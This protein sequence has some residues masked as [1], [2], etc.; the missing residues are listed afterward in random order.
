ME[1]TG[2]AFNEETGT[3]D[4]PTYHIEGDWYV[5]E[6][7]E[8]LYSDGGMMVGTPYIT[9]LESH[10]LREAQASE[11]KMS[12]I[13]SDRVRVSVP[14]MDR[15]FIVDTLEQCIRDEAGN[16]K[17][18]RM[19]ES[20]Y[21]TDTAYIALDNELLVVRSGDFPMIL[22]DRDDD[23][24]MFDMEDSDHGPELFAIMT[25]NHACFNPAEVGDVGVIGT[26]PFGKLEPYS[27]LAFEIPEPYDK[28]IAE[29]YGKGVRTIIRWRNGERDPREKRLYEAM[30]DHFIN[31][32]GY[33]QT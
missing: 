6:T 18:Y 25:A 24:R 31:S 7:R 29:F 30:V 4:I 9:L 12:I 26:E 16:A 8:L 11:V 10:D 21:D 17:R 14:Y 27:E 19:F 28:N 1:I 20:A 3:E 2:Y 32:C 15:E 13:R 22:Q 33:T 5:T 23:G